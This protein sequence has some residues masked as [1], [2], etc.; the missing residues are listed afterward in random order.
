MFITQWERSI[1]A[2]NYSP[3]NH[4]TY[5]IRWFLFS[6]SYLGHTYWQLSG[7][8]EGKVVENRPSLCSPSTKID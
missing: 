8:I 2:R 3:Q 4:K 7:A 6:I 5:T 1:L